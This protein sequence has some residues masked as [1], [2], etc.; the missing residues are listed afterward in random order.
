ME[1]KPVQMMLVESVRVKKD[2]IQCES[3]MAK[4]SASVVILAKEYKMPM[5]DTENGV[6]RRDDADAERG[7]TG[8]T[9][10]EER[11][12]SYDP[13]FATPDNG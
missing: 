7:L 10:K 6:R 1:I 9:N 13:P 12:E 4:I 11:W 2:V 5:P 8:A 3:C